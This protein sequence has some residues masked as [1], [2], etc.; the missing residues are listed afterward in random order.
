[1]NMIVHDDGHTNIVGQDA[2]DFPDN[3]SNRN[4]GLTAE[5]FDLILTNPPFG[6]TIKRTEKGDG[7]LEQFELMRYL[8]KNYPNP[9]ARPTSIKTEI[10]FLERIHSFLKPGTGRA[11]VVLPDGI[12]TNSSL[13]GVRH[14]ILEHFQILGVVSLPPFAFTPYGANVKPSI[15]FLRRFADDE[16][17]S[18]DSPIFMAL[19]DNI[20]YNGAD[21]R[22]FDVSTEEEIPNISKVE[23]HTCDLFDYRVF[24]EW[25]R[26]SEGEGGWSELRREVI[27]GT[28]LVAQWQAFQRD[29]TPFFA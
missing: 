2:L 5:K 28:G 23:R 16:V 17:T 24:Y 27:P 3:I 21:Q 1:M 6:A 12:L 9:K 8:G 14:W 4:A 29:P 25:S 26:A 10:A 19:T 7:Y 13:L 22:T 11:A 18:D 15:V 20:G